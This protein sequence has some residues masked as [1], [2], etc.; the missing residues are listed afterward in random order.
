MYSRYWSRADCL[1][2]HLKFLF[3]GVFLDIPFRLVVFLNFG[4][5]RTLGKVSCGSNHDSDYRICIVCST[6][7]YVHSLAL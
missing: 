5:D 1:E 4:E 2:A 7:P 3:I 6:D